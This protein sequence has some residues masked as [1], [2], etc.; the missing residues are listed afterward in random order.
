MKRHNDLC[1][2]IDLG[3]TNS[4]IATVAARGNLLDT[5]VKSVS[6]M[7]ETGSRRNDP[8]LPSYVSYSGYK[9]DEDK[10]IVGDLAKHQ[11]MTSPHL[12]CKSVKSQMGNPMLTG[13][14]EGLPDTKPEAVSARI[15]KHLLQDLSLYHDEEIDDVVITVPASSSVA[16]RQATLRAAEL[17]G[18]QVHNDAGGYD[19]DLLLSEPEAVMY[20]VINEIKRG[21][22]DIKLDLST[23]KKI[24]VFDIG[25]GTLDITLHHVE[26]VDENKNIFNIDTLA[27]NRYSTIAGDTFDS[28][29]A[30]AMYRQYVEWYQRQSPAA[31]AKIEKE[32]DRYVMP[33]LCSYA[34]QLKIKISDTYDE[35]TRR[36][37]R[38]SD[39]KEFEYGG[40]MSIGYDVEGVMTKEEFET[41]L[42]PLMGRPFVLDDY[43]RV[44]AITDVDNIIY[45]VLQVLHKAANADGV[46]V[47]AVVLNGGMSKLYLI[48]ERLDAFFGLNTIVVSDPDKSVAQGA[49]VYHYYLHQ[50]FSLMEQLRHKNLG[51]AIDDAEVESGSII[52]MG[53]VLNDDLYLG[54][55][56]GSLQRIAASGVMLPYT[57]EPITGFRLE[58]H[59]DRVSLPIRQKVNNGT[60][61]TVCCGDIHFSSAPHIDTPIALRFAISRNQILTCEAWTYRD[62]TTLEPLTQGR[63]ELVF[64]ESVSSRRANAKLQPPPGA[65]LNPRNELS[66][67]RE[68]CRQ[69]DDIKRTK[70]GASRKKDVR[71]RLEKKQ[72]FLK[73]CGNPEDFAAPMLEY[74]NTGSFSILYNLLAVAQDFCA[75]WTVSEREQL[76][77]ICLDVVVREINNIPRSLDWTLVNTQAIRTLG[78]CG[79]A[80][81]T[82]KVEPLMRHEKYES[83]LLYAFSRCGLHID[84]IYELYKKGAARDDAVAA[85][86]YALENHDAPIDEAL[87][88][89]IANELFAKP[90]ESTQPQR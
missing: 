14:Q 5:P 48:K 57:S 39:D 81:Y 30:R 77:K 58:R 86:T 49:A 18:I 28:T 61:V 69:L 8:L 9:S 73:Q 43:K 65:R 47:D 51:V 34:E 31:V 29:L 70:K 59:Q 11:Y 90:I 35:F 16:F 75:Y 55:A 3:T 87:R 41:C 40:M 12:V 15:I 33:T 6:R 17:A 37:K 63:V 1:V 80:Y 7:S 64:G 42:E 83:A 52:S 25:G 32:K 22:Y 45:P 76:A 71:D 27:T 24:M 36:G 72:A 46:A 4:V 67:I 68:W 66:Q 23:P 38:L 26:R 13:L 84:W 2:G 79:I 44:D 56:G 85:L 60:Y 10:I 89:E 50:N 88:V 74:L 53:R 54:L 20:S 78:S 82:R 62:H 19:D 21:N